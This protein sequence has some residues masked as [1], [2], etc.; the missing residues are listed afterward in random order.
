MRER[1]TLKLERL[2][3]MNEERAALLWPAVEE[4]VEE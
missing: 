2:Q 3:K 1:R 4:V